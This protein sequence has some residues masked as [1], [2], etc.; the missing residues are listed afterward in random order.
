[1]AGFWC[2]CLSHAPP[3][4]DIMVFGGPEPGPWGGIGFRPFRDS[5]V[6]GQVV[7][8][9]AVGRFPREVSRGVF[10]FQLTQCFPFSSGAANEI[11]AALLACFLSLTLALTLAPTLTGREQGSLCTLRCDG[12]VC[13]GVCGGNG[14]RR[15]GRR[16]KMVEAQTQAM[17]WC[18]R[19]VYLAWSLP[20]E[21]GVTSSNSKVLGRVSWLAGEG[22]AQGSEFLGWVLGCWGAGRPLAG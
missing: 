3:S 21:V 18:C 19:V 8:N 22:R 15:E 13:F 9:F 4:I 5:S 10:P 7:V 6:E 12:D 2:G 14:G 1:M 11:T 20:V 16:R 17:L